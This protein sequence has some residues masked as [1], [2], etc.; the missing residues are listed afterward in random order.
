[1]P[2]DG[3]TETMML[4][5]VGTGYVAGTAVMGVGQQ[6]YA[7]PPPFPDYGLHTEPQTVV[8][9]LFVLTVVGLLVVITVR[10]VAMSADRF[11]F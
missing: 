5:P 3:V 6:H 9:V 11:R 1:M 2:H 4:T 8:E 7:A 10:R